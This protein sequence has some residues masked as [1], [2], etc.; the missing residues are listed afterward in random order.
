MPDSNI[1]RVM[2]HAKVGVAITVT[3]Q[4][5]NTS[6]IERFRVEKISV[7]FVIDQYCEN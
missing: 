4:Q 6:E 3:W 2:M 1:F 7:D 5:D